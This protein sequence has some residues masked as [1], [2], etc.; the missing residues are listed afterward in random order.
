MYA[1]AY[2]YHGEILTNGAVVDETSTFSQIGQQLYS[3]TGSVL[4][5]ALEQMCGP[6]PRWSIPKTCTKV[7]RGLLKI[8]IADISKPFTLAVVR[9]VKEDVPLLIGKS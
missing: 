5:V 8:Y 6:N 9:R 4:P 1:F 2:A 7:P 3:S